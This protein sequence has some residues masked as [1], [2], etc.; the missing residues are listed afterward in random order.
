MGIGD[1]ASTLAAPDKN[2]HQRPKFSIARQHLT[3]CEQQ[4]AKGRTRACM[5]AGSD[6]HCPET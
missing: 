4:P 3:P 2:K 5:S 6:A 1:V